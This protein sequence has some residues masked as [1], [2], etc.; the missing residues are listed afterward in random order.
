[1]A[2]QRHDR[3]AA[4]TGAA[5]VGDVADVVRAA[6]SML[7]KSRPFFAAA[8]RYSALTAASWR[9]ALT[10]SERAACIIAPSSAFVLSLVMMTTRGGRVDAPELAFPTAEQ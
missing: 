10:S 7:A 8:S 1:M 2:R 4:P 3:S 6:A 5:G 9:A